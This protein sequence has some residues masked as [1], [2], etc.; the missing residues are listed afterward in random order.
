MNEEADEEAGADERP[1]VVRNQWQRP[2]VSVLDVERGTLSSIG[3]HSDH[4]SGSTS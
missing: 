4:A 2:K 1:T 3:V